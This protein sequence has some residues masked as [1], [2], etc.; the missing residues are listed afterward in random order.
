M[1]LKYAFVLR[2]VSGQVVAVAV[3]TDHG[4]FN[5]MVKL[6]RTGAF[7]MEELNGKERTREELLEAMVEKYDVS[8]ERA[9][10]NLDSFLQILRQGGLLSE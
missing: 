8:R 1:K 4:K 7:L 2:E 6:N 10:S 3:G 5:G 9:W